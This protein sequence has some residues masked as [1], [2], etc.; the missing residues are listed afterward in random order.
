MQHVYWKM[1]RSD[2]DSNLFVA[3]PRTLA[4]SRTVV[5]VV[6]T[7]STSS[8]IFCPV[9]SRNTKVQTQTDTWPRT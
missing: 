4:S 7:L 5:S 2:Q 8:R 1:H 9:C 3:L 6:L